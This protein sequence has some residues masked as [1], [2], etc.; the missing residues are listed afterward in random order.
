L[1]AQ[2]KTELATSLGK[3]TGPISIKCYPNPFS[4]QL[5]IVIQFQKF[6][7]LDV[8]IYDVNG[9]LV[10][11]LY[12]SEAEERTVLVWD[13]KNEQG[14]RVVQGSYYLKANEVVEKIVL[15]N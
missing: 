9:K 12:H 2:I 15:K 1:F 13:G 11:N 6:E 5:S 7:Q 3:L 10:R 8:K 4:E 14:V